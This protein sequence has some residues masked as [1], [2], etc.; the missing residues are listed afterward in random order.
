MSDFIMVEGTEF[1]ISTLA[2]MKKADFVN[3]YTGLILDVNKAWMQVEKYARKKPN[4][5]DESEE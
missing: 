4:V 1:R 3:T 5:K 2:G